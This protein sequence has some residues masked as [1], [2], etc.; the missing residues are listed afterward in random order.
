MNVKNIFKNTL[1]PNYRSVL[2]KTHLN[3]LSQPRD[4]LCAQPLKNEY[5]RARKCSS[6]VE[7]LASMCVE[8]LGSIKAL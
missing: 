4:S 8:V 2:W 3:S 1:Y 6:I 5:A 7:H